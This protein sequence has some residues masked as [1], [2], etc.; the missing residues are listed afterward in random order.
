MSTLHLGEKRPNPSNPKGLGVNQDSPRVPHGR[1]KVLL[2][3]RAKKMEEPRDGGKK[4]AAAAGRR[5]ERKGRAGGKERE[6]RN[7]HGRLKYRSKN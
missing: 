2:K 4:A 5:E 6:K 7:N 1:G 3:D